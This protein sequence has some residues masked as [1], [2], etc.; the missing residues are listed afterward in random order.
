MSLVTVATG[1]PVII[2]KIHK[3]MKKLEKDGVGI[4]TGL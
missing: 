2:E 1:D 3:L 4:S